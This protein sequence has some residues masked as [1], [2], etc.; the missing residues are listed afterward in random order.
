MFFFQFW[1]PQCTVIQR[2]SVMVT[3]RRAGLI[4]PLILR[5]PE[6]HS[7]TENDCS[8]HYYVDGRSGNLHTNTRY[9]TTYWTQTPA[10]LTQIPIAVS[11][12]SSSCPDLVRTTNHLFSHHLLWI[13]RCV[14]IK[15]QGLC[16]RRNWWKAL[17][18][19]PNSLALFGWQDSNILGHVLRQ[20]LR[21]QQV[22]VYHRYRSL[23]MH[24]KSYKDI[25][26]TMLQLSTSLKST[27]RASSFAYDFENN[28]AI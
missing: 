20:R 3:R 14:T 18:D 8:M 24:S 22:V 28:S 9:A 6:T 5:L 26:K 23:K 12:V 7:W 2:S 10:T 25:I 15:S 16:W 17:T 27:Y 21:I 11:F 19:D 4:M 13:W 1:R